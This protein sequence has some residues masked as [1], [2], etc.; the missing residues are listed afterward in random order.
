M[1]DAFFSIF[2]KSKKSRARLGVL[3]TPHGMVQTP[4]FVP[5][6][7]K[8][9]LKAVAPNLLK[10]IG[11]QIMFVNTFHLVLSPGVDTLRSFRGIHKYASL[12]LPLMSDSAGFQVFS[13]GSKINSKGFKITE[14]GVHFKSPRDGSS[15]FISP[16]QSMGHQ[17]KIGADILM[18]F[19]ECIPRGVSH[20]YAL[21][22]TER[23]HR[24]LLRCIKAK[25]RKDQRLY[26]IVQGGG[27][28]DLRERSANFIAEQNVDGIA[29]G[30]VSVGETQKEMRDQVR[31]SAPFLPEK[32]PRHLLGV[33][34]PQDF[35]YAISQG[36]D[37]FDCVE[38]TRL[39]RTGTVFTIKGKNIVRMNLIRPLYKKDKKPI[40]K[41]CSCYTC[42]T[43]SRSYLHHLFREQEMLGHQLASMHNITM[44]NMEFEKIRKEIQK[45][46]L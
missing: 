40:E 34:R 1:A 44:M 18:A 20:E 35:R 3:R 37:T 23:T 39:A 29:I 28:K 45:G 6:A 13:L 22:A 33:G 14:K 30:G 46:T 31:W 4:S 11:A 12:Q 24:W 21:E 41:T 25:K 19:D 9:T 15:L 10:D 5:V 36:I 42:K 7:T 43:F 17:E 8:G 16:E 32:L 27:F 2:K 26:G 38:P